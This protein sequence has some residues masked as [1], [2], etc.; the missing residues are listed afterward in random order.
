[1][2]GEKLTV[3]LTYQATGFQ[4]L[5]ELS[6]EL[7]NDGQ[8]AD[9]GLEEAARKVDK[10][11]AAT[12]AV[13]A[14]ATPTSTTPRTRPRPPK[15]VQERPS[16]QDMVAESER[17]LRARG[18]DTSEVDIDELLDPAEVKRL[19]RQT[20]RRLQAV[21]AD[22]DAA[23]IS[24]SDR[25]RG[26]GGP[27]STFLSCAFLKI[28]SG[29]PRGRQ[30]R[31]TR[32]RP[33]FSA[34]DGDNA[35]SGWAK[36]AYDRVANLPEPVVGLSGR[37]HRV[38]TLGHDPLLG[39][40][41]GTLD[42]MGGTMTAVPRGGGLQIMDNG[43]PLT[44]PFLALTKQIAHLLSDVFTH[45][46]LPLPG[47]V[48]LA[49]VKAG[50]FGPMDQSVG[51][52]AQKHVYERLR[53]CDLLTMMTG[54]GAL[55]VLRSYWG[56]RRRFDEEWEASTDIQGHVAGSTGLTDHPRFAAMS[57][58]AHGVATAANVGKIVFTDGNPL[59]LNYAQWAAFLS[60]FSNG[61][62]SRGSPQPASWIGKIAPTLWP[63]LTAGRA[64]ISPIRTSRFPSD[65]GDKSSFYPK[66]W[67]SQQRAERER[68]TQVHGADT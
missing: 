62:N 41:F 12:G 44:N 3:G 61:L 66:G 20:R 60:S 39:M 43:D 6:N 45:D 36:T 5:A 23:D 31:R 8:A 57:L 9:Q 53:L 34:M 2:T 27:S 19:N 16:W 13:P 35:L 4:D 58:T 15:T 63:S 40:M 65:D 37:T 18:I 30:R 48:G 29:G 64:L 50:S 22:L 32:L 7:A 56:L 54:V 42:I 68:I 25:S 38:Q 49:T 52:I 10:L 21:H 14:A 28:P 11:L 59:A 67:L 51:G 47:W 26:C 17:R 24:I 1:M 46:G 33:G 55:K